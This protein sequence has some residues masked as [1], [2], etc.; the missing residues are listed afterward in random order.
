MSRDI[1]SVTYHNL[2]TNQD[3]S[4]K[5]YDSF[6]SI[7]RDI[8]IEEDIKCVICYN[9]EIIPENRYTCR[10][11]SECIVCNDCIL[12]LIKSKYKNI[13]ICPVCN[14]KNWCLNNNNELIVFKKKPNIKIVI[15]NNEDRNTFNRNIRYSFCILIILICCIFLYYEN[16]R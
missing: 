1:E 8:D 13:N 5:S 16:N 2:H 10:I 14:A 12:K 15:N 11:C 6:H 9:S 3:K 4:R 7:S